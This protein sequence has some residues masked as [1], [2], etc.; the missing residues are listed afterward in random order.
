M[1]IF[2]QLE[3]LIPSTAVFYFEK[4]RGKEITPENMALK[5]GKG[6][7]RRFQWLTSRQREQPPKPCILTGISALP[8][9]LIDGI[10]LLLSPRTCAN[11]G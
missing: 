9:E 11:Y 7:L 2:K 3:L 1:P 8:Q 5:K 4:R 6:L 10:I